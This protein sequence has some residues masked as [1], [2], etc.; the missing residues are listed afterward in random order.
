MFNENFE[1]K[2]QQNQINNLINLRNYSHLDSSIDTV[3]NFNTIYD[4]LYK[5]S[6]KVF[7]VDE[8]I[9][10]HKD[11]RLLKSFVEAIDVIEKILDIYH[12]DTSQKIILKCPSNDIFD[13]LY[14][15]CYVFLKYILN[16]HLDRYSGDR[17]YQRVN[18][19]DYHHY[20][21]VD[22]YMNGTIQGNLNYIDYH[23]KVFNDI[24]AECKERLAFIKPYHDRVRGIIDNHFT[25]PTFEVMY[26]DL[27]MY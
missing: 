26:C 1:T 5:L 2:Q 8:F 15:T 19:L 11:K 6:N 25:E 23:Q 12:K 21:A 24:I 3:Y 7:V 18:S 4:M 20:D 27:Y 14:L 22:K 10:D 13:S 17:V 16:H 9:D